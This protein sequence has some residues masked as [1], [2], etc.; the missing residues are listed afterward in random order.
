[1]A[2]SNLISEDLVHHC[3]EGRRRIRQ[4]EE[5]NL[6]FEETAIHLESRLPL[7]SWSYLDVVVAPAYV[8]LCENSGVLQFVY[9]VGNQG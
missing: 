8:E 1:M 4:A 9:K 7:V 2:L 6:R 3:L 5:H